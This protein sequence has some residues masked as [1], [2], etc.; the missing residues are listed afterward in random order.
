MLI[1]STHKWSIFWVI[2]HLT[3]YRQI[4]LGLPKGGPQRNSCFEQIWFKIEPIYLFFLLH[5][6]YKKKE[7]KYNF[8]FGIVWSVYLI[9]LSH[10]WYVHTV[11]KSKFFAVSIQLRNIKTILPTF[12]PYLF[13]NNLWRLCANCEIWIWFSTCNLLSYGSWNFGQDMKSIPS[14]YPPICNQTRKHLW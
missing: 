1:T 11:C 12:N 8:T 7:V 2:F 14:N 6:E 13:I 4:T 3:L 5:R 10:C 9:H